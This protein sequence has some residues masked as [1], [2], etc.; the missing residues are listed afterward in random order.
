MPL[1]PESFIALSDKLL[2]R[3][4]VKRVFRV[5]QPPLSPQGVP[6][7]LF[8]RRMLAATIDTAI[9]ALRRRVSR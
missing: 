2:D 1:K 3:F 7:A 6:Y 4:S 5:A 8:Q 9:I